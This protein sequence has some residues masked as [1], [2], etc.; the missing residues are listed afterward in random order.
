MSQLRISD[1][2]LSE[3]APSRLLPAL[4]LAEAY[5]P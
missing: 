3:L 2:A 4:L 1:K 5:A